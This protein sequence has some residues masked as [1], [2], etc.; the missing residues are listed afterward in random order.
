[1]DRDHVDSAW[2]NGR[3]QH[4]P[5]AFARGLHYG[6]GAFRTIL[7]KD[8]IIID[9]YAHINKVLEDCG[10]L[11]LAPDPEHLRRQL[12]RAAR[13]AGDAVLKLLVMRASEGRGYA[14]STDRVD[15]LVLRWPPPVFPQSCW[16][17]GIVAM[18][19]DI[20]LGA[21]PRLAGIKHLNR[22]EQVLASRRWPDGVRESILTDESS[23]PICGTRSNLFW[24]REGQLCTPDLSRC[25]VAGVM[26]RRILDAA[27]T[28]GIIGRVAHFQVDDLLLAE[29]AFICNSL[30]GI[31][32]LRQLDQRQWGT[33][34]PLTLRLT[35]SL[36]HPRL[37]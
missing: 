33:P 37:I 28:S 29:E 11:D 23:R 22:L 30:I 1:M 24:V 26:R 20:Q 34:G 5:L 25:G 32:P 18:T 14:P 16:T 31:W 36:N 9:L 4:S 35:Q 2:L 8:N 12:E 6:D 19:S 27:A 15:A 10:R 17:Q 13:S 7:K 3:R 21:Q